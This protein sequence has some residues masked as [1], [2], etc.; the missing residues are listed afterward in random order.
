MPDVPVVE[1]MQPIK[2]YESV[3]M[4]ALFEDIVDVFLTDSPKERETKIV[5][6]EDQGT[7]TGILCLGDILRT[8]KEL[9]GAYSRDEIYERSSRL[10]SYENK[11]RHEIEKTLTVGFSLKV[12]NIMIIERPKMTVDSSAGEALDQLLM[13]NLRFLPIYDSNEEKI[14]GVVHA[15]NLYEKIVE[16]WKDSL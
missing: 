2:N 7:I 4:D 8:L 15:S 13:H 6:V 14:V 1:Y 3:K 5:A 10:D 9:T 16:I 12:R 11:N